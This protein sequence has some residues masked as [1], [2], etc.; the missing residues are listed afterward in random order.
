VATSIDKPGNEAKAPGEIRGPLAQLIGPISQVPG[1]VAIGLGG[2]RSIGTSVPSSDFDVIIFS[3]P[4]PQLDHARMAE[5]V[6]QLG[7]K[8]ITSQRNPGE[9]LLAEIGIGNAKIELFFRKMSAIAAEIEGARQGRFRRTFNALHVVGFLSTILISYATYVRP[10]WD[11]EGKLKNLIASAF[12]YPDALRNQMISVFRSDARVALGHAGKVRSPEDLPHLMALYSRV[13]A[14]WNLVL[15][16]ANRQYPVIDKGGRKLVSTFQ[17]TP[18]G[19]EFRSAAIL[20]AAAAG[21]L[22]GANAEA[23][24][25]HRDVVAAALTE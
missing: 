12:P 21:D 23:E 19:Y 17:K 24:R 8:M 3:G 25:L 13:I 22:K 6:Q 4:D 10:V 9:S 5:A 14:S 20:R 2:S 18:P 15:F 1:V 7:G 11:P 16:A